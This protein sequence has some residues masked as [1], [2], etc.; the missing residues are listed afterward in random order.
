MRTIQRL[1]FIIDADDPGSSLGSIIEDGA[2]ENGYTATEY[3]GSKPIAD[4]YFKITKDE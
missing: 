1:L 4:V 3:T 2:E